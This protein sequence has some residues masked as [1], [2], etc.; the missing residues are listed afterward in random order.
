MR[1]DPAPD[2]STGKNF[3]ADRAMRAAFHLAAFFV[4]IG[5]GGRA[6]A[7]FINFDV[8]SMGNPINAPIFFSQTTHLSEL[9]APLG[10]HFAGPG[11]NDGG[12]I[13]DQGSNFGVPAL[14]GPNFLAFNRL[15]QAVMADGGHPIDP[16]TISFDKPQAT[17]S[18]FAAPGVIDEGEAFFGTFRMDAFDV[19]GMLLGTT[20]LSSTGGYVQLSLTS[21]SGIASVKLTETSGDILFVYDNLSFTT[22]P[23]P[24]SLAS[25]GVGGLIAAGYFTRRGRRTRPAADHGRS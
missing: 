23:E 4:L 18:I 1:H 21:G 11:G 15:P 22:I 19:H 5:G 8:D 12:A 9:Y 6:E 17:V 20:T 7:G 24:S 10:V 2:Q 25:L 16:E 13:L 3:M 14:S